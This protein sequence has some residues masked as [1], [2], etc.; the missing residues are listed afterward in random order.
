DYQVLGRLALEVREMIHDIEGV[1]DIKDDYDADRPELQVTIDREKA[2]L[3]GLT[4]FDIANTVR[5]AI[6]GTEAAKYRVDEDEYDITVR[7]AEQNRS[8]IEDVRKINVVY[9]GEQ[10]PLSNIARVETAGSLAAIQHK[11]MK[12]VVTVSAKVEGRNEN[13]ALLDCMKKLADYQLPSSYLIEFTGQNEEQ[14]ESQKFLTEAFVV[15]LFLIAFVLIS[16]FNSLVLPFIIMFSV[17]LSMI[18]VLVGL[19]LTGNSFGIIMT[20]L[21]VISLAGVVVNNAIVLLDYVQKL[22]GRGYGKSEAVIQAGLVRFRPVMLTAITTILG[23]IPL[24]VG[25]GFDFTKFEFQ[26]GSESSQWWGP[27]G[28]A[29][30]FGLGFATLLTLVYVPCMYKLL[31]DL[32]DK[33]GIQPAY[34]RKI[35]H[36]K[37]EDHHTGTG[38][39]R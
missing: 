32:T 14:A 28:V 21:G 37:A 7:F 33:L 18:G 22:R 27:M 19:M 15:A 35:K 20:G 31:T 25:V 9:E 8:S 16:Q 38:V 13:A 6:N 39:I 26:Y 30:I 2:A 24:T 12:R 17:I 29:V 5:T 23:L 10:I 11:D 34:L 3:L 36:A 4:T 1:V